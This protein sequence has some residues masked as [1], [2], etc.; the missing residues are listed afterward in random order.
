MHW[1]HRLHWGLIHLRLL[2][3]CLVHLGLRHRRQWLYWWYRLNWGLA[4]LSLRH[5]WGGRSYRHLGLLNWR[6]WHLWLRCWIGLLVLNW[7]LHNRLSN[8]NRC[9]RCG[10]IILARWL[11][12]FGNRRSTNLCEPL[13]RSTAI[14]T[15]SLASYGYFEFIFTIGAL[16]K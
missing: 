13:L 5:K 2:H 3:W 11:V 4:H 12:H 15:K 14:C 7:C 8:I 16:H 9:N 10:S 1:R 6:R